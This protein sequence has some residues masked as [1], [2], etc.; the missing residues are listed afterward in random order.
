M[1]FNTEQWPE[2][3]VNIIG[4]LLDVMLFGWIIIGL[5]CVFS[6]ILTLFKF[7]FFSNSFAKNFPF[8]AG[9]LNTMIWAMRALAFGMTGLFGLYYMF[10]NDQNYFMFVL[11]PQLLMM[12]CL[13]HV[14]TE[15]LKVAM[16]GQDTTF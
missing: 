10:D 14:L 13:V 1:N 6:I 8:A 12:A 16:Y 11:F 9:I 5:L 15:M 4:D 3:L 2:L 7:E